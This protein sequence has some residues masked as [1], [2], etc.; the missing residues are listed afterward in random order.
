MCSNNKP[1]KSLYRKWIDLNKKIDDKIK[2][3]FEA[4]LAKINVYLPKIKKR[5]SIIEEKA[6]EHRDEAIKIFKTTN[7][8]YKYRKIR[9]HV[10]IFL[11]YYLGR[12]N[13][14]LKLLLI[15]IIVYIIG[16][17]YI[18]FFKWR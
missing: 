13:L 8:Y 10:L 14:E 15:Y 7:T 12:R 6:K 9:W 11:H 17:I 5:L 1:K 18:K 16:Y 2:A 3:E 4:C